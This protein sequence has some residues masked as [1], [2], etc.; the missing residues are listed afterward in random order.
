MQLTRLLAV[1]EGRAGHMGLGYE[2]P[3][4]DKRLVAREITAANR[5]MDRQGWRS[6]DASYLAVEEIAREVM[7]RIDPD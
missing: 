1:R 7:R 6:V 4:V 3:Y 2:N 5:L